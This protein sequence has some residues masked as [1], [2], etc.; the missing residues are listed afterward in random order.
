MKNKK[1]FIPIIITVIIVATVLFLIYKLP[2]KDTG[3]YRS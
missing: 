1:N 2:I 3:D